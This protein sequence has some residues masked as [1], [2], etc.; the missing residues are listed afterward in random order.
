MSNVLALSAVTQLLKSLLHDAL[1]EADASQVL[2]GD[3]AVTALPPDRILTD[4]AEAQG[5][6]LNLYLHRI[7]PNA[8]LSVDDLPTRDA[9]GRLTRRPRLALDLH[10]LLTAISGEQ[11]NAE[12]L[13]GFAMQTFHETAIVPR[14]AI[15]N[16]LAAGIAGDVSPTQGWLD[17]AVRLADQVERIRITPRALS[18]DDMSRIWTAMQTSY[19]TTVA[20]D[21]ALVLIEREIAT[22]PSLP[23]L[24]RGG[25]RDAESGR[26]PGVALRPDLLSGVPT[27]M[28]IEPLDGQPVMRLGRRIAL[29]GSALDRGTAT[30][31]FTRPDTGQVLELSP[32]GPSAPIRI[33]VD[34]PAGPPR[35]PGDPLEG[36][37]ADPGA[38][39][40]GPYAVALHLL[41]DDGRDAATNALAIA[42]AP[43]ITA[44]A[45]ATAGGVTVT[46]TC[47]PPIRPGQSVAI[48]V[49]QQ[50]ALVETPPAP[51]TTVAAEFAGLPPGAAL[52]VRLR[53]DGIDSPVIDRLAEPPALETVT[54]P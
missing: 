46:V 10:Y 44:S 43:A 24:S 9:Q 42:L 7:T 53:V 16:A 49:G 15:R 50:M 33:V 36:S 52:P 51:T 5:N 2:G 6:R 11:L 4:D 39:R 18:L 32:P 27:L 20:Y 40:I 26:D 37:G 3:F 38:W 35:P 29:S 41:G 23:V 13:L 14:E 31:R 22:R 12:T 54:I 19:R 17:Q 48:L 1:I 45:T 21:V 30:V 47:S 8:A 28:G 34:L 25:L